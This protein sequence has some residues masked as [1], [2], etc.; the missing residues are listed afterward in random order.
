MSRN[1]S[2]ASRILAGGVVAAW[3]VTAWW[4]VLFTAGWAGS[5]SDVLFNRSGD[6][7]WTTFIVWLIALSPVVGWWL[8]LTGRMKHF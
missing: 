6:H 7:L 3:T 1:R 4:L 5:L 2:G 8:L